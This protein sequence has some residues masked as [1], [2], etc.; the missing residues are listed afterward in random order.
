MRALLAIVTISSFL[1]HCQLPHDHGGSDHGHA[2][3]GAPQ[4]DAGVTDDED[5]GAADGCRYLEGLYDDVACSKLAD[6]VR[7]YTP[8]F[9]LFADGASKQ[10]FI[11]LPPD[12]T[13]D[14]K[15]PDRWNFPSGTR[16]YKT[17]SAQGKRLETRVLT[18]HADAPG[19]L[20]SWAY[21]AYVWNEDGKS[22]RPADPDVNETMVRGVAH[23]VPTKKECE[24]CHTLKGPDMDAINGF[25]AIQLNHQE[26]DPDAWTLRRLLRADRLVNGTSHTLNV[27]VANAVIP[28]SEAEQ[29]ALGYLHGNCGN[30]HGGPLA[31]DGGAP[32]AGMRLWATVGT[33][34]VSQSPAYVDAVCGPLARW[35]AD[36][37][38]NAYQYRIVPRDPEHSA[39][40][41][42]MSSTQA[43][44]QMPPI[45]RKTVDSAGVEL[46]SAFIAALDASSCEPLTTP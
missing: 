24:R 29:S 10:R 13:I 34:R 14:T 3:S 27:S 40:I 23:V 11:Y 32:A 45:G 25:G 35:H 2:G 28:G 18:K 39:I 31:A 15:N 5:A 20:A 37:D 12:R 44:D 1:D 19:L 17:F 43:K 8:R 26:R 7:P 6:G 21:V 36:V 9:E 4:V 38:G 22:V 30:C 33:T 41:A 16:I 42:R 46:I